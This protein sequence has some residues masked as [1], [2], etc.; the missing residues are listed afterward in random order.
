MEEQAKLIFLFTR[1][2]TI[3]YDQRHYQCLTLVGCL[4][5]IG[6]TAL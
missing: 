5:G 4:V 1:P 6:L 3:P 2:N